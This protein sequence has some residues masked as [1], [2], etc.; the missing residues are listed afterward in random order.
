VSNFHSQ[1]FWSNRVKRCWIF[2]VLVWFSI[3]SAAQSTSATISGGVTDPAGNFIVDADV[4]IANDGTGVVYSSKTNNSGMYLVPI[5]PPGHYH[6][7]I[8]KPGFQTIIK[9]DV[10][11]NVQ[12]ALSLNFVLPVGATS[13]SVTVDAATSLINTTDASVST[14]IDR[15]FVENMPLNGRSFQD[16]ISMTPGVATQSPQA[17]G[18]PGLQGDFSV[19]GQRTESNSYSLDGISANTGAGYPTGYG[20]SATTGAIAAGSALGTTQNLLSVDALQEFRVTSSTYSAEFGRTPGGQFS[21]SSRAGTNVLHGSMYDYLRND[22]FDANN[23]FNKRDDLSKSALRQNDFGGTIGGPI[24]IPH[25]YDGRDR[26]FFFFAYEG[27]RLVLP[28]AATTQYVPSRSVRSSA[29]ASTQEVLDAFPLPTGTE[30]D[31]ASG[32]PSGLAPFIEPYSLPASIDSTSLRIDKRLSSRLHL[33]ARY[34]YSPSEVN[35]RLLSSLT[36][37]RYNSQGIAVGLSAQLNERLNNETRV[38][39]TQSKSSLLSSV[40]AFGGAV[41]TNLGS[42]LTETSY[43][44]GQFTPFISISGVGTSSL[45]QQQAGNKLHQWNITDTLY[46]QINHHSIEFGVDERHITSPLDLASIAVLPYWFSRTALLSDPSSIYLGKYQ[47]SVP[48]F[49]E[50]SAFAQDEWKM[51]GVLTLSFGLR[52][53]V[54]PAPTEATGNSPYTLLGDVNDPLS[55]TLAPRGTPLWKTS[56]YNFAPR[57][58]AAWL[59]NNTPGR[60]TV[61]RAG[62]GVYFDTG[63]QEGAQGFSGI[64]FSASKTVTGSPLPV[65]S[66]EFSSF[67]ITPSP[68]YTGNIVY[69]F[70]AHLQLP[71]TLQWSAA[72]EQAVS[73]QQSLTLSYVGSTG[74][75]L[76]QRQ[77]H[78]VTSIN[79]LFGEIYFYPN[80]LTSNYQALQLKFQRF[81]SHGLQTLASYTWSHSLDYGS[82]NAAYALT[83]GNSDFDVRQNLQAGLSWEIPGGNGRGFLS[84]ILRSWAFDGRFMARTGFPI[85]LLGNAETDSVG[86]FYYTGV[87]YDPSKPVYVYSAQYPGGRALNGGPNNTTA[88]AFSLPSGNTYG[89][90]PRNFVRGFGAAQINLALRKE[91]PLYRSLNLQFRAETFNLLNSPLFGYV[92]PT[93]SDALFGQA[94]KTLNQSLGSM[95][96]LYQQGGPRSLQFALRLSF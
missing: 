73:K 51:N 40:D 84:S 7:Q 32:P 42:A 33:F 64:G 57:A 70:P 29:P 69:A 90:A 46:W 15:K 56:W 11:L 93:L 1:A 78:D 85:T 49:N 9:A 61:V 44:T 30:I 63:N 50:F 60:E 72:I 62:G 77:L 88:P 89:N 79:P 54:N 80:G 75:R 10:I 76:L 3:F 48:V 81:V 47:S 27:L 38:G 58:G 26:T 25:F 96:S 13:E 19:N 87:N 21:L 24:T 37:S 66:S 36:T 43:T 4:E 34:A 71:Y 45:N 41:P 35:T 31:L 17:G 39:F 92:D 55:L 83:R 8:S 68:P 5:L 94:T 28:T 16:L 6:V 20:Q 82:T 12:S 52:W 91:I 95:S 14:V 18:E 59:L 74:R 65:K 53:E 67:S 23:W 22:V 2:L 86:N